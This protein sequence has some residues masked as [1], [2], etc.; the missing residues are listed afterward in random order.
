MTKD[1]HQQITEL[2]GAVC[3]LDEDARR[4]LLDEQCADDPEL[5]AAVEKLIADDTDPVTFLDSPALGKDFELR[6]GGD[7]SP[8][9]KLPEHIGDFTILKVIGEGGMGVVYLAEQAKTK[10]KVA[11]KAIR[12]G[13]ATEKMLRRF[14]HET[15]ILARL[16]HPGIAEIYEAGTADT[17]LGPQPY[18]A[19]ELVQGKPIITYAPENELSTH[20]RLE[21]MRKVCDAVHHAHQKGVIHRDLKPSNILV[22][23]SGQPKILDFGVARALD[24]D[25]ETTTLH[26]DIGQLM[27]TVPYMSPEQA[28]GDSDDLDTRS[29]V[30][31]LGVLSY[32]ILAGR[33]PY[34]VAD[35]MVHEMVR[36]IQEEEPT[37]LSSIN[38]FF[39][40]DLD[41][42]VAKALEKD[43]ERRYQSASELAADINHYLHDE[44]VIARRAGAVHRTIKLL[45]RNRRALLSAV[46]GGSLI[47]VIGV[48]L[49]MYVFVVPVNRDK[50]L[51]T[52]SKR[53]I[54]G[55]R[56]RRRPT[57]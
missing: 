10:R 41:T 16:H 25:L 23:D 50:H 26:T 46:A 42:I 49:A 15:E 36:V 51:V 40:G 19:M 43:K 55:T 1:R 52:I 17:G 13:V 35:K 34:D 48:V 29:D 6:A 30:Y 7:Q 4:T 32:Q 31:A 33:L 20:Q 5:R 3:D 39:R 8:H 45:R 56:V 37:P 54:A 27:G 21:L 12:P 2:F 9:L 38:R 47:L 14:G 11:L 57:G 18:F 22:D 53:S 44:P 28:A 24:T